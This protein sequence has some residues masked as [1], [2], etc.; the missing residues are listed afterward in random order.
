MKTIGLWILTIVLIAAHIF[1]RSQAQ[2]DSPATVVW[3]EI[4]ARSG[5]CQISFPTSPQVV[6][7]QLQLGQE[8][9]QL[10][11]DVYLAPYQE[12]AICLLLVATYPKSLTE[13]SE[14]EGLDGLLR[15][16]VGQHP[17]NKLLF[18]ER[19]RQQGFPALSF[20]VQSR[21]SFFR[22]LA[23]MVGNKLYMVAMEGIG[24]DF[25][26]GAFQK[27]LGSFRLLQNP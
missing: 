21:E 6:E 10:A 9:L 17:D 3:Q 24:R 14:A 2:A 16:I 1:F 4:S 5:D 19:I 20:M 22:G 12:R 13:H 26:E 27:F 15:G 18:A 23:V 11:Y 8:G 25:D 7:Q